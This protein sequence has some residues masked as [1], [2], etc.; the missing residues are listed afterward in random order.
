MARLSASMHMIVHSIMFRLTI[1]YYVREI[2]RC[3]CALSL[4]ALYD[5]ARDLDASA[6]LCK[7][8]TSAQALMGYLGEKKNSASSSS[9]RATLEM[10][11]V[12][13]DGGQGQGQACSIVGL[14]HH[15]MTMASQAEQGQSA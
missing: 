13:G 12:F 4:P 15:V 6:R 7:H 8:S 2:Y 9:S 10:A 1:L 5:Q 11:G 14:S 3:V